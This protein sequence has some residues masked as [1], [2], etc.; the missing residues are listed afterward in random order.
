MAVERLE[1]YKA[2]LCSCK[3]GWLQGS[4]H[5]SAVYTGESLTPLIFSRCL[6]RHQQIVLLKPFCRQ[7]G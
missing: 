1:D 4:R 3:L 7:W 6:E 2:A 5:S